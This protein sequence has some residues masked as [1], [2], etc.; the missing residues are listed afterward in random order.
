MLAIV[1]WLCVTGLLCG[2]AY[3]LGRRSDRWALLLAPVLVVIA[4]HLMLDLDVTPGEGAASGVAV[5]IVG[6]WYLAAMCVVLAL[7]LVGSAFSIRRSRL[8]AA[9]F[10]CG[11][12]P[13]L[14]VLGYRLTAPHRAPA[15][16]APATAPPRATYLEGYTWA[17]DNGV[18]SDTACVN[19]TPDFIAGCKSA[20]R[21]N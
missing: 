19:G 15:P 8:V 20:V 12:V 1:G 7:I 10:F 2:G 18:A 17:V 16:L 21:R 11:M 4:W 6:I 3:W 5:V 9:L 13:A 14:A